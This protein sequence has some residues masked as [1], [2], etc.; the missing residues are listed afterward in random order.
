LEAEVA[1]LKAMIA[2]LQAE[3]EALRGSGGGDGSAAAFVKPNK[4]SDKHA[5]RA[6]PKKTRRQRV[7][8]Q[9]AARKKE[10]PERVTEIRQHALERCPTCDY[11]LSGHSIARRRQVIDLPPMP[12]LQVVE[13]QVIKRWCPVCKAWHAPKLDLSGEVLGQRRLGHGIASLVS[14]LRTT[15]RLPIKLVQA[16]VW[17][18]YTLKLSA[19]EIVELCHAVANAGKT[20]VAEIKATIVDS[21]QVH[22]DETCW[23]EDG[24]NGY[25]WA[26]STPDGLRAFEFHFSRAGAIPEAILDGFTGTLVTDFYAGYNHTDTPT[27]GISAVGCMCCAICI[28]SRP[29]TLPVI[30]KCWLGLTR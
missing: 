12:A 17:Q 11:K 4:H 5:H 19:G 25:V 2:S 10:P 23:R 9:N 15:L 22:M 24:D 7:A 29:T 28:S 21:P 26:S 18:I 8:E 27:V 14:W 13:H 30:Q 1:A 6:R 20:A 3:L 16:L